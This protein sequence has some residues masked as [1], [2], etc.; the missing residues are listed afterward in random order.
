MSIEYVFF[1]ETLHQRFL[2][3]VAAKG[4]AADARHD[5]IDGFIVTLPED[6]DDEL[7]DAIE[8][9]YDALMR[10]QMILA[11]ADEE[12]ATRQVM[13]VTVTLSDGESRDVRIHGAIGRKLTEHF[14]PEEIHELVTQI[15]ESVV[16]PVDGPLCRKPSGTR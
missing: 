11:E 12:W 4:L 15:A 10:E 7:S 6:I 5:E 1:N 16:N 2:T 13:G 9:E 3:F 8:A 14:T